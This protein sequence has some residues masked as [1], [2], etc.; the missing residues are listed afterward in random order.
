MSRASKLIGVLLVLGW[1]AA[2]L[3]LTAPGH[4]LLAH[5]G[6]ATACSDGCS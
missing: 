5:L 6:L 4:R 1:A 2:L 3:G